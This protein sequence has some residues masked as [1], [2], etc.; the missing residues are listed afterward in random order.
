MGRVYT[1]FQLLLKLLT[2]DLDRAKS[3]KKES[4]VTT[5]VPVAVNKDINMLLMTGLFS[6]I[7]SV[8]SCFLTRLNLV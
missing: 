4:F 5:K 2:F 1:L 8:A 3:F 7:A 6:D